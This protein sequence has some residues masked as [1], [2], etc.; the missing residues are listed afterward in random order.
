MPHATLADAPT[1]Q[2]DGFTFRPLAVPSRGSAEL[3][4]WALEVAP[5]AVSEPHSV[6]REEVFVLRSG[7]VSATVAGVESVLAAGDALIVPV[8]AELRL[9]NDGERAAHLT[10]CTS[11]GMKGTVGGQTFSP[12]WAQ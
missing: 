1:F 4:V 10:A 3:A 5:G 11:A 8:G 9:R 2:R 7:T 12:P 6:D